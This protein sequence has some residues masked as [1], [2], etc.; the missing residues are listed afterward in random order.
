MTFTLNSVIKSKSSDVGKKIFLSMYKFLA[1][2]L[3]TVWTEWKA[4]SEL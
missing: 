3:V 1:L 2:Q 4:L